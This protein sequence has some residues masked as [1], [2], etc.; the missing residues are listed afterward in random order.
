M[1]LPKIGKD[2][3]LSE[4]AYYIIKDAILSNKL[5][6]RERLSEVAL[7]DKLGISRTPVRSALKKLAFER[8]V[9][10]KR[11]KNAIVA[12]LSEKDMYDVFVIRKAQEPVAAEETAKIITKEQTRVL[13]TLLEGQQRA[14]K[15]NDFSSYLKNDYKFHTLIAD[16]SK[17]KQL[18]DIVV[19]INNQVKR[20][21]ILSG[22]LKINSER[23]LSEHKA[24]LSA[25]KQGDYELAKEQMENH[26]L[27]VTS[28][29]IDLEK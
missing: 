10:F 12:D 1:N 15:Q 16:Y 21:L 7:A 2:M 22:T 13:D 3:S 25:F 27:N 9:V 19:S 23:A 26:I 24:V 17:N 18:Y 5:K 11:N 28:R 20:F 14:I 4:Q 29:L 8:L 6:P